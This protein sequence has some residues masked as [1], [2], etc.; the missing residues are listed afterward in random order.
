[1]FV[2]IVANGG[3]LLLNVGPS[4]DGAI[5]WVQARRL[6]ALG[7]WLRTNGPAVYGSRPWTR[8]E[9]T[10]ADGV[11][12]RFTVAGDALYA[13][14]LG[15]PS[16]AVVEL[17]AVPTSDL[18]VV[19]LLGY[20]APLTWSRAGDGLRVELPAVP[21]GTPAPVLRVMPRQ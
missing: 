1:M 12:V 9:G 18:T 16:T 8:P 20:E 6:L 3:N 7:W 14:L 10:T 5:P 2:D 21:A 13:I 4:A 19:G 17:P 15:R 11:P